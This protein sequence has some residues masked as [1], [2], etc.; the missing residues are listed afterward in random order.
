MAAW[1]HGGGFSLDVGVRIEAEADLVWNA[2]Y[3]TAPVLSSRSNRCARL[4]LSVWFTKASS[5]APAAVSGC[6]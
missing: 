2:C 1:E 6:S 4:I 5:P 3:G